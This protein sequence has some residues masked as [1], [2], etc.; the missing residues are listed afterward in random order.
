VAEPIPQTDQ[1]D[2]PAGRPHR[3]NHWTNAR[4]AA[5]LRALAETRS[6]AA[7]ARS[8]GMSRQSAYKLRDRLPRSPFTQAWDMVFAAPPGAFARRGWGDV[9]ENAPSPRHPVSFSPAGL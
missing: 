7:A 1:T 3:Y 8:V 9:Q 2:A 4:M 6:V 5:F